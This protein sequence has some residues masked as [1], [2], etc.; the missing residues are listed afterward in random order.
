MLAADCNFCHGTSR[1]AR[2][3]RDDWPGPQVQTWRAFPQIHP[4]VPLLVRQRLRHRFQDRFRNQWCVLD[5][6]TYGGWSNLDTLRIKAQQ[7]SAPSH[8]NTQEG[9]HWLHLIRLYEQWTLRAFFIPI[10]E[11]FLGIE[12]ISYAFHRSWCATV[13]Q[14]ACSGLQNSRWLW[15]WGGLWRSCCPFLVTHLKYDEIGRHKQS[16]GR[17]HRKYYCIATQ[18]VRKWYRFN[19]KLK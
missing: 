2:P 16:T 18:H 4:R 14:I 7:L 17:Y 12:S 11:S 15:K 13:F 19:K 5:G 6:A 10:Q 9:A 8:W 1:L 3:A